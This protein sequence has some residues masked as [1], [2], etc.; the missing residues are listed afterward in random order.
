MLFRHG[1]TRVDG[2]VTELV[3]LGDLI[4]AP[5]TGMLYSVTGPIGGIQAWDMA[6]LDLR[7][8]H[9]FEIPNP[10]VGNG[11]DAPR[12]LALILRDGA[13]ALLAPGKFGTE[14]DGI[15]LAADGRF[16]PAFTQT[17]MAGIPGAMTALAPVS[18]PG[19]TYLVSASRHQADL[20]VWARNGENGLISLNQSLNLGLDPGSVL[21][22][23]ANGEGEVLALSATGD[24]LL[25][26]RL[27]PD[28]TLSLVSRLDPED[29]LYIS[30]PNLLEIVELAG[31]SYAVVGAQGSS[32]V[33]V[34]RL[35]PGG[36]MRVTDHVIDD[37]NTR[38]SR[39]SVLETAVIGDQAYVVAGGSD[40]GITVMTLL[41]GGR[42]LHLGSLADDTEMAL[43][44][45]MALAVLPGA[46]GLDIAVA[47]QAPG[48]VDEG[49]SGLGLTRVEA[50]LGP[51]GSVQHGSDAGVQ[52][53]GGAAGDQIVGGAVNDVLRGHGGDDILIDGAGTD[54]L[55]GGAG[56][57]VFILVSDGRT[58]VITDFEPGLDRLDLSQLGLF[59]T[60]DVLDIR[61]QHWGAEIHFA[62]ETVEIHSADGS[63]LTAAD[64]TIA[65]LR[66]LWHIPVAPLSAGN[67]HIIGSE[68]SDI[69]DGG[70]GHDTLE[71]GPGSDTL[72]G[73]GGNDWLR[74][75]A[76]APVFDPVSAQVF[77][78]YQA[79]LGRVPDQ[80]GLF[81]W[82]GQLIANDMDLTGVARGFVRSAEFQA[83]YGG[84]DTEGFVS[85]LYANV[86][87]RA[88]DAGGL[89]HWTAQLDSGA[90]SREAVVVG[91][92]E[93]AEFRASTAIAATAVSRDLLQASW[94]A[95]V[96]QLYQA[97]LD[98]EP[99]LTG[100]AHWTMR[101]ATGQPFGSVV[102]G[103][104]G[105]V[106]F[107]NT[108]GE[109]SDA[110]FV[111][112]LYQNVLGR[113]PDAAGF[114]HWL[115]RL[116]SGEMTR[117]EV[118]AG[119]SRSPEFGNAMAAPLADWMRAQGPDDRLDGG[120]GSNV[121]QGGL[122]SD[123]FV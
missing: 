21:G 45:P 97:T 112:L 33:S 116:A 102:A 20:Q 96:F 81:G 83:T 77:R 44:D 23:K 63:R 27:G 76:S 28:G 53:D 2:A 85:L 55:S 115:G 118:V 22:L 41:P 114:A 38:F 48:P 58:D 98:R 5:D 121:L 42:L 18:V 47:G 8:R 107:R 75:G 80:T 17:L 65:D 87:D 123:R 93:S 64:F 108:Y 30:T 37:L 109:T 39:I 106:E 56:R 16:D 24:V 46:T 62:A 10:G 40:D 89:A 120:A 54:A 25:R 94:S 82:S 36:G 32:S 117:E 91:F 104:T 90:L 9:D 100:F 1:V 12:G 73:Q 31:H 61:P 43:G 35:D 19:G 4:A 50:V 101:L 79:T 84:L 111:T 52:L 34:V 110:G 119:F 6:T 71:G 66:D 68:L 78:L 69:L 15:G 122:M 59:Y 7:D 11:L 67:Q 51:V 49:D 14:L 88:P 13:P 60:V 70:P 95:D 74:G 92:S 113:A 99:D 86:L 72:N 29:G 57:D 103:F 3:G 26:L 105:S